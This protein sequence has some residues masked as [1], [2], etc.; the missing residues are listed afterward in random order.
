MNSRRRWP[1]RR[2]AWRHHADAQQEGQTDEAPRQARSPGIGTASASSAARCSG[3]FR[4]HRIHQEDDLPALRCCGLRRARCW[5]MRFLCGT[6]SPGK[7]A[8]PVR[9]VRP[10]RA[11]RSD[12]PGI[13]RWRAGFPIEVVLGARTASALMVE[14]VRG[15]G[16]RVIAVPTIPDRWTV[17]RRFHRNTGVAGDNRGSAAVSRCGATVSF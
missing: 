17:I 16:A 3:W 12:A 15:Y 14:Q 9:P 2:R 5:R 4:D 7:P 6:R 1:K 10:D 8:R 13:F 11:C